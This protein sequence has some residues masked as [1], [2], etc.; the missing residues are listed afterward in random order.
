[1][2]S[3][4]SRDAKNRVKPGGDLGSNQYFYTTD[5]TTG[6]ITVTRA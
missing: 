1:M 5:K 2:A 3:Y 4:G 6:E